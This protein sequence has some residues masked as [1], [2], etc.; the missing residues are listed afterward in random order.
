VS[1]FTKIRL[2]AVKSAEILPAIKG[3]PSMKLIERQDESRIYFYY[4]KEDPFGKI[5]F[6]GK[7]EIPGY[8]TKMTLDLSAEYPAISGDE[9]FIRQ[10]KEKISL[11]KVISAVNNDPNYQKVEM[12]DDHLEAT[13]YSGSVVKIFLV[14]QKEQVILEPEVE[15]EGC[16]ALTQSLEVSLGK[17][18]DRKFKDSDSTDAVVFA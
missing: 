15:G 7:G 5:L 16:T 3:D 1:H 10:T 14:V 8:I 4:P 12:I 9:D 2:N 18:C 11:M 13:T 17:V 6:G